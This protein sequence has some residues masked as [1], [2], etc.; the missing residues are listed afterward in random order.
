MKRFC[1]IINPIAGAGKGVSIAALIQAQLKPKN[2]PYTIRFTEYAGQAQ[3]I[4]EEEKLRGY[5]VFVAVGGDGTV[6]EVASALVNTSL[7]LGIIPL[8]SG[9]G[10]ARALHIPLSTQQAIN[11]VLNTSPIKMDVGQL[12]EYYFFCTAGIGFDAEVAKRFHEAPTR[13]L[14]TYLLAVLQAFKHYDKEFF[15]HDKVIKNGYVVSFCNANQYGN[16]AFISPSSVL[17]D[18]RLELVVL[19]K[20]SWIQNLQLGLQLFNKNIH[21][22]QLHEAHSFE[23]LTIQRIQNGPLHIDGDYKKTINNITIKVIPLALQVVG[24]L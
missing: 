14:K 9:N 13:G 20:G 7:T 17:N 10:L 8:G 3:E 1:F 22:N 12:N 18:G 6:N 19:Q 15:Y 16:N 21:K 5:T 23:S 11:F 2:I 24:K 4:I